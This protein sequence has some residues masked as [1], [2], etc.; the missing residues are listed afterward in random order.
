[1]ANDPRSSSSRRWRIEHADCLDVLPRL[2]ADSVDVAI[3]D[4]PYGIGFNAMAWDERTMRR[5]GSSNLAGRDVGGKA[6]RPNDGLASD[7][8]FQANCTEWGAE[9]LRVLKPGGHIAAFGHPRTFHRLACGLEEAGLELRDVLMWLYGQGFP[10]S[11]NLTGDLQGWGTALRPSYEPILLARKALRGCTQAN[12]T[13]YGT[14]ALNIEASRIPR[15]TK[16]CPG[17]RPGRSSAR[18]AAPAGRW[19]ANLAFSHAPSCTEERCEHDCPAALL[20]ERRR[21]F[22]CAKASR[23]ERDAGCEQLVRRTIQ[24]FQ[25]GRGNER[26]ARTN[27]VANVHPTVKPL[28]LMRWL[29]RLLT[30]P[31]GLVLDPFAGSGSTGAA[32][33]LEGAR[34]LGVEREADYVSIARARIAHWTVVASPGPSGCER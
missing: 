19:P 15:H 9:C 13:L 32:A 2:G 33:V 20:G 18:R 28:G 27:L 6:G 16:H 26:R 22:Y 5:A 12:A 1:M 7:G 11:H 10:K 23:N 30:P 29:V 31:D 4:P 3:T 24:T 14:G 8:S 34:F 17:E 25:I 21:F